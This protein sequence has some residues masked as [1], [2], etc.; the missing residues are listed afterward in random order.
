MRY[1]VVWADAALDESMTIWT[2]A[3]DRNAVREA[4][5]RIDRALSRDADSRGVD[6]YGDR[7]LIEPPLAVTFSVSANDRLACVIKVQANI[8]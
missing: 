4:A 3:S 6:F 5:D 7:L 8:S 2:A 1:T